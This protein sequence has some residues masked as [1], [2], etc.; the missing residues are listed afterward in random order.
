MQGL[1]SFSGSFSYSNGSFS[2]VDV[3]D[4]FMGGTFTGI[5]P[6]GSPGLNTYALY[7]YE[8]A[9]NAQAAGSDVYSLWFETTQPLGGTNPGIIV[10]SILYNTDD[11]A[12]RDWFCGGGP[13]VLG[14]APGLS[15]SASLVQSAPEI[16]FS[17]S[18]A[19]LALLVGGTLVLKGRRD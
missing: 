6:Y 11:N 10:N 12:D 16:D 7:D 8:G 14:G 3:S 9:P 1:T 18:A 2:S 15:C 17:R 13:Q 5:N 19:A 4:N